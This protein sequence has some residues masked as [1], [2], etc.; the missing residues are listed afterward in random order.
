MKH[1]LNYGGI[2]LTGSYIN[3][4]EQAIEFGD[5]QGTI[6]RLRFTGDTVLSEGLPLLLTST[7]DRG[8]A[9][10]PAA[11]QR[12][13]SSMRPAIDFAGAVMTTSSG[14]KASLPRLPVDAPPASSP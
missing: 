4:A 10:A 6:S 12:P 11:P 14:A 7:P 5:R 13:A 3:L 8:T 1:G 2:R 9:A